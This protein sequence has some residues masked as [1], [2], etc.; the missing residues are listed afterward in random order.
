MPSYEAEPS[1]R[2]G[3]SVPDSLLIGALGFLLG[4]TILTWSAAGLSGLLAHGTWPTGVVFT[5]TPLAFRGLASDPA[6]LAAAWPDA[7]PA[8]LSGPGLFWGVFIG[9]LLILFTL[10]FV[11]LTSVTR[12]RAY[13]EA[14][15]AKA[16]AAP[17]IPIPAPVPAPESSPS[18]NPSPEPDL[19]A[20]QERSP[21]R[22]TPTPATAPGATTR[23]HL[24]GAADPAEA[25][26]A[27]EGAAV[28]VTANAALWADT[29]GARS[30]LGPTHLYDPTHATDA[31]ARISWAPEH[32]CTD[33]ETAR[34][35]AAALLA[36]VRSPATADAA[37][38]DA[39]ETL[40]RCCL[41]AAAI[42]GQ[43]FRQVHRWATSGSPTEAVRILRKDKAAAPGAAGELE[44]TLIAHPE[45]RDEAT[46]L[47]RHALTALSQL[48]IRTVCTAS[49]ADTIAL[50]SFITEAG[51]LYIVGDSIEDPRRD[52]GAM[53]LLTALTTSVVE[54]GRRM[55]ARSSSGRLDPPL[56]VILDGPAT[57][58]P[59]ADLPGL[60]TS[61]EETG[62]HT[63]A[64][65]R[66]KDQ[67]H[68][69]W[70]ELARTHAERGSQP[71]FGF[72]AGPR[73]GGVGTP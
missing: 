40:L 2:P 33:P 56:T 67:A 41:H 30:K 19:P 43:P 39:A 49:R 23:L 68:A 66:S 34:T 32:G 46:D 16:A 35:R 24:Q 64:Y 58:A 25:L 14:Q 8:T 61:G 45:R 37:V 72:K 38:H 71:A 44:A 54:H 28:V 7:D 1:R 11:V 51:T 6:D 52:P 21:E 63:H 27:A 15:R 70:P 20:Q 3:N 60:L 59:L 50:E 26:Q 22:I 5:R 36:P 65:L 73:V 48:H 4:L 12:R 47:I 57:V 69:W 53:P 55:A 62:I 42:T 13:R 17:D 29:V 31:P 18:P 9:Q 10:A